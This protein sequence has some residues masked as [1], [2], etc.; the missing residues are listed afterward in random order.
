MLRPYVC[1]RPYVAVG[2]YLRHREPPRPRPTPPPR[3]PPAA[4]PLPRRG[5]GRRT[6]RAGARECAR[7][8]RDPGSRAGWREAGAGRPRRRELL[9]AVAGDTD[10]RRCRSHAPRAAARPLRA[11][12]H[13]H[14][15]AT[16][17]PPAPQPP[18]PR[19]A[20]LRWDGRVTRVAV[21][22]PI[23]DAAYNREFQRRMMAYQFYPAHTRGGRTLEDVVIVPLRIGN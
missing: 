8:A 22:P 3:A 4:P 6:R 5:A 16:A 13:R 21:D 23:A 19:D 18:T 10:L 7:C 2:V 15:A 9:R 1:L 14:R 12:P 11:A 17:R 20:R